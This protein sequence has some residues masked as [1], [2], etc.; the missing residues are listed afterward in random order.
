[1]AHSVT[2]QVLDDLKPFEGRFGMTWRIALLCALVA[3]VAMIYKI[4]EPAIGC[5][6]IIYLMKQ[7]ASTN[8]V[9][10]I[11]CAILVTIFIA[12]VL[13]LTKL[14]IE[15]AFLRLAVMAL[16]SFAFVYLGAVSKLGDLGSD[17][18]L[19]ITFALTL[20]SGLPVG[21]AVTRGLLYA[22]QMVTMP[23][24]LM[25]CFNLVV[26]IP[27]SRLLRATVRDRV[28]AVADALT[29]NDA[30]SRDRLKALL[31]EGNAEHDQRALLT[32]IL[33][34]VPK[35]DTNWLARSI[36]QSYR[37][38]LAAFALPNTTAP[39]MRAR[40]A[41]H[42]DAV[43]A[44]IAAKTPIPAPDAE[45][46][47][48]TAVREMWQTFAELADRNPT[49]PKIAQEPFFVADA[50]RNPTYQG[51]ALKTTLAAMLSY[52]IY[53]GM[54]WQGIHT[55]MITCFVA[56]LGTTGETVH[57]LTLRIVGCLIGAAMGIAAILFIIPNLTSVGG[58]MVLVFV[59]LLP[60]AWVTSGSERISYG[61]VQ[62]GLAFLLTVLQ[63][64]EPGISMDSAR[65]RIIGILLGNVMVYV[66]FTQIWPVGVIDGVR[67]HLSRAMSSLARLA[68]LPADDRRG[69]VDAASAAM[70]NL[71]QAEDQLALAHFEPDSLRPD[72]S[73]IRRLKAVMAEADHLAADLVVGPKD[74]GDAARLQ[75]LAASIATARPSAADPAA[76]LPSSIPD[77]LAAQRIARIEHVLVN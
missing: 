17:M 38:L 47:D 21:E 75:G 42:A 46:S 48:D 41:A 45:A 74:P 58:L 63:G 43:V 4:P 26:G 66:I 53:A 27:P 22:W 25:V 6:L 5:Y 44:A 67:G 70:I 32:R 20:V 61:G 59:A 71:R 52:I 55:A 68:A 31:D 51:F 2:R 57:K 35:R 30:E 3:A 14:T 13:F 29:A 39:E 64:F 12:L 49:W 23:M 18:A 9:M 19:V 7:D 54:D 10:G 72:E 33:H 11:G 34:Y 69:A 62:I 50:L 56:A 36:E 24:A 15:V 76:S 60:A 65:D 1:M 8:I 16:A 40:L 37:L 28:K 77:T 73:T